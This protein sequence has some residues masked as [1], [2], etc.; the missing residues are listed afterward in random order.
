MER[1]MKLS[2]Y[3]AAGGLACLLMPVVGC[4]GRSS[5]PD[6]T[7]ER[8][9]AQTESKS[10]ASLDLGDGHVV[11]FLEAGQGGVTVF[12][13]VPNDGVQ[14]LVL[15]EQFQG[16]A[17]GEIYSRLAPPN[18]AVP[19]PILEA[20]ARFRALEAM[21]PVDI[22]EPPVVDAE[23]VTQAPVFYD[24]DAAFAASFRQLWCGWP[25]TKECI[26][27]ANDTFGTNWWAGK[28][29]FTVGSTNSLGGGIVVFLYYEFEQKVATGSW[30]EPG[31]T[32]AALQTYHGDYTYWKAGMYSTIDNGA[33]RP[34]PLHF[35]YLALATDH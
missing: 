18:S 13:V 17:P 11:K 6:R 5:G 33:T 9:V 27:Q 4:S 10:L 19:E 35:L 26:I 2:A 15:S 21:G 3:W 14:K 20:E 16:M 7:E 31:T 24:D 22:G 1:A 29:A 34:N 23:D 25:T 32:W 30:L 12:E 28:N 8:G